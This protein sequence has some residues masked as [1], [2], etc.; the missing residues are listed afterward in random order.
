VEQREWF[1][2]L[3]PEQKRL[4]QQ[5]NAGELFQQH[6]A[7]W[8]LEHAFLE[9][10]HA[11]LRQ[12]RVPIL[13]YEHLIGRRSEAAAWLSKRFGLSDADTVATRLAQPSRSVRHSGTSAREA[14]REDNSEAL[15]GRWKQQIGKTQLRLLK[16]ALG[17]FGI[18]AYSHDHPFPHGWLAEPPW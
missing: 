8:I 18:T 17:T 9:H 14:L 16:E 4:I 5:L 2:S 15:V 7:V 12:R 11:T 3:S 6:L 13:A 1:D 10:A